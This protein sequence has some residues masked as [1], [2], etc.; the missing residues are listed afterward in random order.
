MRFSTLTWI[1]AA[2]LCEVPE[3]RKGTGNQVGLVQGESGHVAFN[4]HA[5]IDDFER[6][7]IGKVNRLEDCPHLMIAIGALPKNIERQVDLCK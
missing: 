6:Q 4:L 7:S 3:R 1:P 2:N 5:S